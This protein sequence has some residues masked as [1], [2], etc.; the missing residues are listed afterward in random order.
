MDHP[1]WLLV[2]IACG[3]LILIFGPNPKR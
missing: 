3:L 1:G 2:L